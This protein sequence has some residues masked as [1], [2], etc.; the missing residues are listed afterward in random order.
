MT[1]PRAILAEDEDVL[2]DELRSHLATLWPELEIVGE[3]RDGFEALQLLDRQAPDLIFLD[4]Q[5]PGLSG[6]EV[7]RQ[8]AGRCHVVFVTAYDAH[9]VAAFE[10]GAVDYV[11]KPYSVE[12]LAK[13]VGRVRRRLGGDAARLDGLLGELARIAPERKY[14]RWINASRG[15]DVSLITVDEIV[16][17]QADAKYT[18][19]FTAQAEALIRRPLKELQEELDPA[20]FWTIHRSTIVN[21]NAVS[22]VTRDLRGRV[23]VKLKLRSELLAVSEAHT[24]Q[25]RQM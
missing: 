7:A 1:R 10:E 2:R 4:I 5:M 11:L 22:G 18:V 21:A 6:L 16:Y 8:A 24:Q 3:A 12:R 17:F 20:T 19:V 23:F 15:K 9:A 14:L 25:F 13:A